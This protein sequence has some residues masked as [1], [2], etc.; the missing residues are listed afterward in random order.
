MKTRQTTP[1]FPSIF[2]ALFVTF[3]FIFENSQNSFSFG[4]RFGLLWSVKYLNFWA[5]ATNSANPS[6]FSVK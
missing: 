2:Y 3:I 1:F 6:Y 4:P 5:K